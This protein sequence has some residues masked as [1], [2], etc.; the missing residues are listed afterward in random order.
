[1]VSAPEQYAPPLRGLG[2]LQYLCCLD[3]PPPHDL[4][5]TLNL[6]QTVHPPSILHSLILQGFDSDATPSPN[7]ET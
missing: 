3:M 6:V 2:L 5:Q 1:M 4:E 7:N